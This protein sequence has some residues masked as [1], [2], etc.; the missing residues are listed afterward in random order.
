MVLIESFCHGLDILEYLCGPIHSVMCEQTDITGH[1]YRSVALA[2]RFAS[3]AVG[4]MIGGY[5]SSFAYRDTHILELNGSEARVLVEDTFRTFSLQKGGE[6]A[7]KVWE[8]GYLNDTGRSFF[9]TLDAHGCYLESVQAWRTATC[10]RHLRQAGVGAGASGR[11]VLPD[12][13]TRGS[14]RIGALAGLR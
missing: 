7:R 1:G 9:H 4:S 3:G 6:E 2:L 8:A 11:R 10:A 12:G 13:S 14:S 5:D